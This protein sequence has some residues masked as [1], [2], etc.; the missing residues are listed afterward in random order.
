MKK[1][2]GKV[3]RKRLPLEDNDLPLEMKE[4]KR[5]PS[6]V[7]SESMEEQSENVAKQVCFQYIYIRMELKY[8]LN[9]H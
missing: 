6:F 4:S 5:D 3:S 8:L 2:H 9:I 7:S 1:T